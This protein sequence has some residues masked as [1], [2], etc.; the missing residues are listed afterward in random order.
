MNWRNKIAEAG[1][2]I[3]L[4]LTS[5]NGLEDVITSYRGG[6][7]QRN[8]F[9]AGGK[10]QEWQPTVLPQ[11]ELRLDWKE[12]NGSA[13]MLMRGGQLQRLMSALGWKKL[14]AKRREQLRLIAA[15]ADAAALEWLKD[16]SGGGPD[17]VRLNENNLQE[18]Y[19]QR[20][21]K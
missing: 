9:K 3:P 11:P 7:E 20:G 6:A 17:W 5:C 2:R 14:N 13:H 18:F 16:V 15:A 1:A 21:I 12:R 4:S 10:Y 19:K 8:R